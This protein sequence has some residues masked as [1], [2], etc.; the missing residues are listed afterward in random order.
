M[1][2]VISGSGNMGKGRRG[3]TVWSQNERLFHV[4]ESGGC[5]AGY[6]KMNGS[7]GLAL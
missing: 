4:M 1:S 5:Q 3:E 7:L 6:M 2:E